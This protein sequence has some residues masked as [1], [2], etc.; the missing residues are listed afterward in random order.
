MPITAAPEPIVLVANARMP[1]QRA[2]SLQVAQAAAAFARHGAATTLLHARRHDTPEVSA[3]QLWRTFGVDGP[4]CPAAQAVACI[5]WID[6]TPR[7]MQFLPA[8]IQELTFAAN[9]A[10]RVRA[11]HPGARVL[12]R[13][14]ET[15]RAL[16]RRPGVFL[17]MHR[18]PGGRLRRRWLLEAARGCAGLVAISGGVRTDLIALGVDPGAI[19]VEHDAYDSRRY[20]TP[21]TRAA[22]RTELGLDPQVP[23]VVYTGGLLRW[24]G[25]DV[26]VDAAR[27]L[28]DD[29]QVL[30]VGGMD[31]DVERLRQRAAGMARVRI[32]GFRAADAVPAY[33]AAADVAVVPNRAT[34]AISARYTSPLKV[35]EAMAVGVPLVVSDLPSLRDILDD[36][37]ALFVPAEDA[38]ALAQ[39][40]SALL[41]SPARRD[42]MRAAQRAAAHDRTWDARAARLLDW[43]GTRA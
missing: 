16:R 41:G 26:L 37:Q 7:R 39:G 2:Q 23:V 10:R 11:D 34:P 42:E 15:A 9:A 40:L 43:M 5:D 1:S 20:A 33:L 17:E 12:S 35:F 22:A 21:P 28:A 36:E 25:V 38:A 8:R 3:A 32:D 29:V 6:R 27:Q 18:V 31:R 19:L 13:E 14:L 30:I 24:K 4:Q